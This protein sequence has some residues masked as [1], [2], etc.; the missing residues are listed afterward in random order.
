MRLDLF[1]FADLSQAML[2]QGR[3]AAFV[4]NPA[5]GML[6]PFGEEIIEVVAYSD[7]WGDYTD[8]LV[9]TVSH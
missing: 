5:S 3:G 9:C 8:K 1:Y 7:M 4:C 2:S 6:Q